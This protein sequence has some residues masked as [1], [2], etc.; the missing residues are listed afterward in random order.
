MQWG[1]RWSCAVCRQHLRGCVWQG[2]YEG[3]LVLAI[4]GA[5]CWLAG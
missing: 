3:A 4:A 5:L 2:L 1:D